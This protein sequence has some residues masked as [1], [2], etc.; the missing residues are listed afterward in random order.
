MLKQVVIHAQLPDTSV[1]PYA[2]FVN[3]HL[4]G[5]K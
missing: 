3:V 4:L 5:S 2:E 1:V